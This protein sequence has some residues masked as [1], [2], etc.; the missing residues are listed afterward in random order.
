PQSFKEAFDA[1]IA[2]R[3]GAEFDIDYGRKDIS[4]DTGD[5]LEPK[6]FLAIGLLALALFLFFKKDGKVI[7]KE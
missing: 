2:M 6:W 7:V 3:K 4:P 1:K 5:Y